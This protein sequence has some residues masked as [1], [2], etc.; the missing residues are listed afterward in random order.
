MLHV[1]AVVDYLQSRA[2]DLFVK[3]LGELEWDEFI[4][5]APQ[6]QRRLMDRA[7][8][9]IQDIFAAEYR[10]ENLINSVAVSGS[11]PLFECKIDILVEALVVKCQWP[12][13]ANV[14][15]TR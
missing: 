13:M 5:A 6:N 7:N 8:S 15:T 1:T 10:V 4:F 12:E 14:V 2:R 3:S 9:A 11:H